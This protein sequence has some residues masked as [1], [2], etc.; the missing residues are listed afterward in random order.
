MEQELTTRIA[1]KV[2]RLITE[3]DLQRIDVQRALGIV[4]RRDIQA[5]WSGTRPYSVTQL[6]AIGDLLG[7][8]V[9]DLLLPDE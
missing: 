5:L 3:Q 7:V 2:R 4:D 6:A 1:A 8:R 9:T